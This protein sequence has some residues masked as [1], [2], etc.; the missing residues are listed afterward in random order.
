M[1][2]VVMKTV[3]IQALILVVFIT[4]SISV[5]RAT[6]IF[7][8]QSE[9]VQFYGFFTFLGALFYFVYLGVRGVESVVEVEKA[10]IGI[11]GGGKL[12]V[13]LSRRRKEA[14]WIIFVELVTRI[15]VNELP[16]DSGVSRAA[17]DSV[18]GLFKTVRRLTAES[19][20]T[21]NVNNK[22]ESFELVSIRFLNQMLRPFL[23]KWHGLKF[24]ESGNYLSNDLE[25]REDLNS[26]RIDMLNTYALAYARLAGIKNPELLLESSGF[27]LSELE[28]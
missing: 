6:V 19:G 28:S 8:N 12:S 16:K 10:E 27:E 13:S 25:F 20:P 15:G 2:R 26:L 23:T 7:L 18:Y 5:A 1:D 14:A 17:M 22:G 4:I 11:P 24:D 21:K 9:S 3:G